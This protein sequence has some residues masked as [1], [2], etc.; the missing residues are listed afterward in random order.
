MSPATLDSAEARWQ[1]QLIAMRTALADLKLP[2]T[3]TVNAAY[4]SDIPFDEDDESTSGNSGGDVWD[5]ISDTEEEFYSSD[6]NDDHVPDL[7]A[8][9]YAPEW[10]RTQC[11]AFASRKQG[12]SGDDLEQQITALLASDSNEEELQSTLTDIIGF[13][14]LDFVIELIS[15]RREIT[16]PSLSSDKKGES[17][18]GTLQTKRQRQ[19]ALRQRDYEHKHAVLGPSL[20]RDAPQYPHVYTSHPTAGNILDSKGKKYALP[21]GHE[22]REHDVSDISLFVSWLLKTWI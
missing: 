22:R 3:D 19:E 4:E 15:H 7:A 6:L 11:V 18:F 20:N 12:L 8:G 1:S 16:T 5:F 17:I 9:Q 10:L 13:D 2:P 14:D 21:T